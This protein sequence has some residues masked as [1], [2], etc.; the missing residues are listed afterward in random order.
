MK[1]RSIACCLAATFLF[2]AVTPAP[3]EAYNDFYKVFKAKYVG[4]E[5]TPQQKKLA[6]AI[7]Q[8]KKCNVCHDPRKINGKVSKKNRNPYGQALAKLL[9][10][11]DKKAIDKIKKALD[12]VAQQKAPSGDKT[13]GER[14]AAGELPVV[15]KK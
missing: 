8:V 5:A 7:K 3:V 11:K 6:A 10:K 4:D 13:F 2:G 9:T 14:L 12:K 15:V 1:T